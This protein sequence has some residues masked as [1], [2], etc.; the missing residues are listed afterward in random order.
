MKTA[1]NRRTILLAAALGASATLCK[2]A[3]VATMSHN[4]TSLK[5]H[6]TRPS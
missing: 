4:A 2:P 1:F 3:E 6:R 5:L